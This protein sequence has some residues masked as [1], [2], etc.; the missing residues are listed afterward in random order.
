MRK[1]LILLIG[2]ILLGFSSPV[3]AATISYKKLDNIYFNLNVNGV[4]SSNY[5]TMFYLD[6]RLAYCIEPGAEINT[7]EYDSNT[8]WANTNIDIDTQKEIE[9]IGYYGYE[10]TNHQTPKFYIATQELIWQ[11]LKN[12]EIYFTTGPNGSGTIIDTSKEKQEILDLISKH[13]KTP[14][15]ANSIITKKKGETLV[16]EDQ[17]KVLNDFSLS[18]S[19][20]HKVNKEDNKLNITFSDSINEETLI[21]TRNNYYNDLLLVYTKPGSQSLASLRISNSDEYFLTLKSEDI[22]V[23]QK[24]IVKVPSTGDSPKIT[25]FKILKFQ[26]YDLT[27]FI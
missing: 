3:E 8:N 19:K 9:K 5:V 4:H 17:N 23:P 12:V 14:S 11:K 6:N 21:L 18:E 27:H 1:T 20:F 2:I 13:E 24:E 25:H 16:L 10:Y 15:F 7:R 26:R 22:P